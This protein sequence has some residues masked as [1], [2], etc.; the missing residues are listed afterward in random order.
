MKNTNFQ[1][2]VKFN[3]PY[4]RVDLK[5]KKLSLFK[6]TVKPSQSMVEFYGGTVLSK[7]LKEQAK[8][9]VASGVFTNINRQE[10]RNGTRDSVKQILIGKTVASEN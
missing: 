4:Y 10:T 6:K 9:M 3:G 5:L 8:K 7:V 1:I 2:F